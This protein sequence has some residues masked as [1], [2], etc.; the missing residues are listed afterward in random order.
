MM[1]ELNPHSASGYRPTAP[2]AITPMGG[3]PVGL[4][5][6]NSSMLNERVRLT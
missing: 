6:E 1:D 4:H 2:E 3:K 5:P